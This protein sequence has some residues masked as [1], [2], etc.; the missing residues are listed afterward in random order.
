MGR[1]PTTGDIAA[2]LGLSQREV[3]ESRVAGA[4]RAAVSLHTPLF[5]DGQPMDLGDTM[6]GPDAALESLADRDALR[7]ALAALPGEGRELLRLRFVDEL[8]QQ[9]IAD[10]LGTSQMQVSRLLSRVLRRLRTHM[11][12]QP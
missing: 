11:L 8:T 1:Q 10:R 6:G 12:G 3:V 4:A 5:A 7:R 9:Q 2:A